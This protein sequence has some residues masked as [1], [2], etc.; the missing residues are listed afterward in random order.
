MSTGETDHD[1]VQQ[2]SACE[3]D[4]FVFVHNRIIPL[5][6]VLTMHTVTSENSLFENVVSVPTVC[7]VS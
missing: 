3:R 4:E 7:I 2:N 5:Y 1:I 6:L